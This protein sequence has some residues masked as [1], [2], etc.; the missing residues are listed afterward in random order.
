MYARLTQLFQRLKA[1]RLAYTLTIV[2]TLAFG[3][4]IGTVITHGVK[5]RALAANDPAPLTVPPAQKQSSQFGQIARTVEPS[6]VNINTDSVIKPPK[7]R[8]APG[9]GGGGSQDDPF[10]DFFDRFFGSPDGGDGTVRERSLGS[11]VIVDANGYIVTN[12][13]VIDNATRVRVKLQDDPPGVFHD[14]E[15]IGS[16][17]ETDLAVI[18]IN[19]GRPLK[20][21]KIGNSE[22]M[23]V[24][25]WVLAIGSPFGL[26]ETVTAGIVSAKGR[27]IVPQRQ[28]QSFVQTDAAINPGNSGGPL[29]NLNGEVVGINTAIYTESSGYEGVGFALPS[30]TVVEV[31]NQLI[32][33]PDHRVVR[34]SIGIEFNA[35]PS[36]AIARVY[37]V[38]SGGVI[39][40]VTAGGPADEGGLKTGDTITSVNGRE[41]KSGDE[42]VNEISL[43]KPGTKAHLG[44]VRNG[45]QQTADITIAD[46]AKLFAARLGDDNPEGEETKPAD[47]KLGLNVHALT[48]DLADRL[49]VPSGKGV[50]VQD[51]K[52]GSFADDIGFNRGDVI[53]QINKQPVNSEDD[54][55]K[56][57]G[58]LK[59]GQDVV[60]LVLPR[61]AGRNAGTIFL[62]GTLP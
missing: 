15:I 29:V 57:Q 53:L 46:R 35:Q 58:Q 50:V 47:S 20:A 16:D 41:V 40:N 44:Y 37:G 2:L 51:V 4:L 34:G 62:A 22:S 3:I 33:G 36:P 55:R 27:N 56:L 43:L 13:H 38:G 30:N 24:G 19:A 28:F 49:D 7:R 59:S 10:H 52:P 42:L 8:R 48:P 6:V 9:G 26:E 12:Q 14:A 21:A 39:A 18:K 5:G 54:F 23:E 1:R 45:K 25:D 31:Y 61:S 32:Q 17:K 60:F 11:G